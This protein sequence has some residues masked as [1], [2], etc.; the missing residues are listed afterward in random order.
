MYTKFK[1]T[2]NTKEKVVSLFQNLLLKIWSQN[3]WYAKEKVFWLLPNLLLKIWSQSIWYLNLPWFKDLESNP[4]VSTAFFS[5]GW[6][7]YRNLLASFYWRHSTLRISK[8]FAQLSRVKMMRFNFQRNFVLA[9]YEQR[10]HLLCV[11]LPTLFK[12]FKIAKSEFAKFKA[13]EVIN[14][15]LI[16]LWQRIH[17]LLG[18]MK[19]SIF[20]WVSQYVYKCQVQ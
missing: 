14:Y 6:Y 13:M 4:Q 10:E 18:N 11:S 9:N 5:H 2:Q 16:S 3:I 15:G 7:L 8:E 12:A 20:F 1:W 19:T 17:F